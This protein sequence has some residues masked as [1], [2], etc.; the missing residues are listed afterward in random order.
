MPKAT[1]VGKFRASSRDVR[2]APLLGSSKKNK[3]DTDKTSTTTTDITEGKEAPILSRGQRKRLAKRDQYLK[4]E[5]MVMSSL[6]L[7]RLDQEKGKI[8]GLEAIREALGE[9]ESSS[10]TK[11]MIAAAK[12]PTQNERIIISSNQS[13]KKLAATEITHMNLVL[14]HPS[15]KSN[16]FDAIQQ[17]LRNSLAGDAKK[18]NLESNKRSEEDAKVV[19]T[20]KEERKER[21]RNAKF[22]KHQRRKRR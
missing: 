7:Q 4:R 14:Q 18:L 17:H 22:A 10:P 1:K 13:K 5:K 9:A 2:D 6:R 16:P 11:A 3:K 12:E 20:K 21:I 15:F 19:A 8:D